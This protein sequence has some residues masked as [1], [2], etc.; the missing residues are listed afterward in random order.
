MN[1]HTPLQSPSLFGII[2]G[3]VRSLFYL[4]LLL[5]FNSGL[6]PGIC[7]SASKRRGLRSHLSRAPLSQPEN[8]I[9]CLSSP[10][11]KLLSKVYRLKHT[12]A[13]RCVKARCAAITSNL[14]HFI[15]LL[16]AGVDSQSAIL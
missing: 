1:G 4:K 5:L 6:F 11:Q 15:R 14:Q 2:N 9:H 12:N 16:N 13:Q 3:N 10:R 8:A 7:V